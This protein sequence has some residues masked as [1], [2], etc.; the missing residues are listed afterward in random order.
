MRI[1]NHNHTTLLHTS[2]SAQP[3][4]DNAVA[5]EDWGDEAGGTLKTAKQKERAKKERAKLQKK[6]KADEAK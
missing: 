1:S 5:V 3:T 2:E 6:Q 4:A